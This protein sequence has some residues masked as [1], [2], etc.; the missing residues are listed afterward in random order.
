[1]DKL[2]GSIAALSALQTTAD[3]A[4]KDAPSKT[5]LRHFEL[6]AFILKGTASEYIGFSLKK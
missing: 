2:Q 4:G 1:M 5:I 3:T 6:L